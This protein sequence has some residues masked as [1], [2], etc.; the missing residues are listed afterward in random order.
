LSPL[1]SVSFPLFL[2]SFPV[3]R[4]PSA[5]FSLYFSLP[6]ISFVVFPFSFH[7]FTL[8]LPHASLPLSL[9]F[10][11]L[12]PIFKVSINALLRIYTM[13]FFAILNCFVFLASFFTISEYINTEFA[14]RLRPDGTKIF[15]VL[16]MI[17]HFLYIFYVLH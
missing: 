15:F 16:L 17:V 8:L 3:T 9:S 10:D 11:V 6:T 13:R 2:L 4:W 1:Y 14:I 5:P 7:L 12:S